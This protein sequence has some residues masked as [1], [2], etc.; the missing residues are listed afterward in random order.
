MKSDP[1]QV[2]C[3]EVR[4]LFAILENIVSFLKGTLEKVLRSDVRCF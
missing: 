1:E 2:P 4:S 3:H